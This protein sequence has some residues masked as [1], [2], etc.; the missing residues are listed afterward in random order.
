MDSRSAA[1]A[2]GVALCPSTLWAASPGMSSTSRKI[3]I[4]MA[5]RVIAMPPRRLKN[6]LKNVISHP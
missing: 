6:G 2:C 4:D 1:T 3:R 5:I